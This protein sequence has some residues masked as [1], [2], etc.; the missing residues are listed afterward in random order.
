MAV[1]DLLTPSLDDNDEEDNDNAEADLLAKEAQLKLDL[2][3]L[4]AIKEI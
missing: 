2:A 3:I 4:E 1:Q